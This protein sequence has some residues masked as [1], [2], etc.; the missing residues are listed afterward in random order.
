MIK[1]KAWIKT[2]GSEKETDHSQPKTVNVVIDWQ[3]EESSDFYAGGE[4]REDIRGINDI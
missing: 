1:K 2:Q 3:R 4:V